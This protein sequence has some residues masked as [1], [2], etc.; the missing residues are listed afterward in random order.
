MPTRPAG[1]EIMSIAMV[2]NAILWSY[3]PCRFDQV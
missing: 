2:T 3:Q 1:S